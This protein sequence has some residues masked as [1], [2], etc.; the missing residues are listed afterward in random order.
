L[1]DGK[2]KET[3]RA[4]RII[5]ACYPVIQLVNFS[6]LVLILGV[7]AELGEAGIFFFISIF[8]SVRIKKTG[9]PLDFQKSCYLI[10]KN[11]EV[12]LK[13]QKITEHPA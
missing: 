1:K 2:I 4:Y 10:F 11:F 6:D 8:S 3:W 9:L 7:L 13:F 5:L 12:K